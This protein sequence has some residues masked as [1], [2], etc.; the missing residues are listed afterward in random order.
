ME[1]EQ[2]RPGIF[3]VTRLCWIKEP[4]FRPNIDVVKSFIEYVVT[5]VSRMGTKLYCRSYFPREQGFQPPDVVPIARTSS[6]VPAPSSDTGELEES[7]RRTDIGGPSRSSTMDTVTG[8]YGI[9]SCVS[10]LLPNKAMR[11]KRMHL[12]SEQLFEN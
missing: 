7:F 6:P 12:S 11:T 9:T 8:N 5:H 1:F 2:Y 4:V 3:A 10:V